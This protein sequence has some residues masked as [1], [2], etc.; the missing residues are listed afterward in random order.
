VSRQNDRP[1]TIGGKEYE[2]M[3]RKMVT[4]REFGRVLTITTGGYLDTVGKKDRK[5]L[6]ETLTETVQDR[7]W[8]IQIDKERRGGPRRKRRQRHQRRSERRSQ[9]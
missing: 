5:E 2:K 7:G 4:S 8:P 3:V 6:N 9:S 1:R